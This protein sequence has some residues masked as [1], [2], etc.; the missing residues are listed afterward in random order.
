LPIVSHPRYT[1][2]AASA[3]ALGYFA[4]SAL[5]FALTLE[6]VPVSTLWP[7]NAILLA[8]LV[9]TPP[10][11]WGH[12]LAA[13]FAAHLAVQLPGGVPP[14]MVLCWF[15]SNATEAVLG[16]ALLRRFGSGTPWFETFRGTA[17]FVGA[18]VAAAFLSSFV[19][20]TFVALNGWGDAS[21]GTLWRTRF[22]S[23]VLATLTLVPVALT[24]ADVLAGSIR[25]PRRRLTEAAAGL[26]VLV[27]VC[28]G[29]F[30]LREP[31]PETSPALLY[32]PLPLLVAAALRFGPW[33]ASVSMLT[34][35]VIAIMGAVSGRGPFIISSPFDNALSLQLFLLAVWI[36]IMSLAAIVRERARAEE[37]ARTREAQ[38][39]IAMDAVQLGRWEWEVAT[40]HLTWSD[41]TRRIYEVPLDGVVTPATFQ[42]LIH[43]EDRPVID[44]AMAGAGAGRDIDAEFRIVLPDGRTKWILS[45]GRAI[46]ADDGRLVRLVGVKVDI[47]VRKLAELQIQEQRRTL[48]QR[49]REWVAGE[50]STALAHEVN[51]PL[52][53]ILCNASAA[54]Q[55]LHR[56]PTDL[57]E[58][59][60][61]V[62]AIADDNREAAAVISRFGALLKK[63]E[64]S[65]ESVDMNELVTS[66]IDVARLDIL[67]RGVRVT[68]AEAA[69]LPPVFG[70]RVQ[71][72]QVLL[73]LVINACEA[74][75]PLAPEARRLHLATELDGGDQGVRVVV[76]DSGPGVP[77]D[78]LERVFEPFVTT[79]RLRPGLGLAICSSIVSAHNGRLGVQHPV[80]GGAAFYF[81]LPAEAASVTGPAPA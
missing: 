72:Q 54:K 34:T 27:V 73:N 59:A 5:G 9:L 42:A 8:G 13:V 18:G 79:K 15:V 65:W 35:A 26:A 63:D 14:L 16:A 47:T 12:I 23:N 75:E 81:S 80:E 41:T 28:W 52:A 25:L 22:F 57:R 77:P 46:C 30:V 43:P 29:V 3:V 71:L 76:R 31:G 58:L 55:F 51:Q 36:P 20:V 6:P 49:S 74:M 44:A 68:T 60:E 45:R 24:S 50:L 64:P 38:L 56:N 21:F 2:L 33:G 32:G 7:P 70:D 11:I 53:A 78:A 10:R 4:G 61:I 39:A 1:I 62:D 48:A 40:Q 67:S 19:D 17:V 66:F 37:Q 69:R